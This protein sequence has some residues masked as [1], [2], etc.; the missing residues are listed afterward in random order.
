LIEALILDYV[1]RNPQTT[2]KAIIEASGKSK[3]STP[4]GFASLQ[5]K[6]I[7][8]IHGKRGLP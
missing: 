5:E 4:E 7:L 1:K 8:V 3:R 6:G 2:Q